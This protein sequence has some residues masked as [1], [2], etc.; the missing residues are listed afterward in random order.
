MNTSKVT[1]TY[2]MNR[3]IYTENQKVLYHPVF[4]NFYNQL[5]LFLFLASFLSVRNFC[6][7]SKF[8]SIDDNAKFWEWF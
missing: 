7:C 1:K 5:E 6:L 2:K 8:K 4:G 3:C